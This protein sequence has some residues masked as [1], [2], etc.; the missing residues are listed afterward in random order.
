MISGTSLKWP[1]ASAWA[2]VSVI[3]RPSSNGPSRR[4]KPASLSAGRARNSSAVPVAG[5]PTFASAPTSL[6]SRWARV[7]GPCQPPPDST[8]A[9][10]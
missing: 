1:R 9:L 5:T 4:A 3:S 10:E 2:D 6:A 7:S 8:M